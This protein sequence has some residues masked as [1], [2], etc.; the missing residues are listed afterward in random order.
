[1]DEAQRSA[2]D[3]RENIRAHREPTDALDPGL[4]VATLDD[5]QLRGEAGAG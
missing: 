3:H 2:R 4:H 5:I 1:M